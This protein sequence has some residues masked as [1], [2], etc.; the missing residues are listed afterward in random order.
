MVDAYV[1]ELAVKVIRRDS[2]APKVAVEIARLLALICK[3]GFSVLPSPFRHIHRVDDAT[4]QF[5]RGH[6]WQ[7]LLVVLLLDPTPTL[8]TYILILL[9]NAIKSG[10]CESMSSPRA[11]QGRVR[12]SRDCSQSRYRRACGV[13]CQEWLVVSARKVVSWLLHIPA[14]TSEP[15]R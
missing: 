4:V 5:F 1:F 7:K 3:H 11:H 10:S 8:R 2:V 13:H 12:W 15:M 14:H 9:R 6:A